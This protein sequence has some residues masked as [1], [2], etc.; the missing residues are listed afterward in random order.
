MSERELIEQELAERSRRIVRG[1][2]SDDVRAAV[3]PARIS[4]RVKN[5]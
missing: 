3:N 4:E 1:E 5:R 2:Y